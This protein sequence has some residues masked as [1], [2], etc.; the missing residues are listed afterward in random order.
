MT[1]AYFL[2][3]AFGIID[4]RIDYVA[5]IFATVILSGKIDINDDLLEKIKTSL[6]KV[7]KS[8]SNQ[9]I[10][11]SQIEY[12]LKTTKKRAISINLFVKKIAKYSSKYPNLIKK[13]PHKALLDFKTDNIIQHRVFEFLDDLK[14][15]AT[16]K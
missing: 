7:Y 2:N 11:Y 8:K 5:T 3:K 10:L 1:I 6:K 16:H 9:D 12:Y 13:I 14:H 4:K 15:N